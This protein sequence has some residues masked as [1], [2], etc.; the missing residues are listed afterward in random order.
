MAMSFGA[1]VICPVLIGRELL[2]AA[3]HGAIAR[4]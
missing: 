1:P 4:A 2:L 3:L